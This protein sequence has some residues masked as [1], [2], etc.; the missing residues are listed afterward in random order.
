MTDG[1]EKRLGD[2]VISEVDPYRKERRDYEKFPHVARFFA[3]GT[4]VSES[5]KADE[6]YDDAIGMPFDQRKNEARDMSVGHRASDR[7]SYLRRGG[8]VGARVGGEVVRSLGVMAGAVP[9]F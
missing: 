1:I 7:Q 8:N 3:S 2:Y 9:A 4:M 6:F 5:Y